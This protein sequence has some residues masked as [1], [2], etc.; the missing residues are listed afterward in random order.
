MME[1]GRKIRSMT[2][3][4]KVVKLQ[5]SPL[6]MIELLKKENNCKERKCKS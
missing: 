4:F 3:K 2:K 6:L 1:M 5:I